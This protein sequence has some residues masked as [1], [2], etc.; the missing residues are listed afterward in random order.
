MELTTQPTGDQMDN[1]LVEKQNRALNVLVE[2]ARLAQ[3]RGAF[4]LEQAALIAEA[5][6]VFRPAQ[7]E[8]PPAEVP[9][10]AEPAV[11]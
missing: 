7:P 1:E 11:F 2:A 4:T 3:T 5:I 10:P 6:G 9:P 8:A